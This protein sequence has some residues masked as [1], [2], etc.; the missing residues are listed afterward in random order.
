MAVWMPVMVVLRSLATYWIDTFMTELSR[1][2]RNW[3]E[4]KSSR[5]KPD[6]ERSRD[7]RTAGSLGV[8]LCHGRDR[9]R[10]VR[11][12]EKSEPPGR[13]EVHRRLTSDAVT[14]SPS[15]ARGLS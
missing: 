3:A 12:G 5:T 13:D 15:L 10:A 11:R 2:M 4:A 6:P 1:V 8:P 14:N 7:A 9:S